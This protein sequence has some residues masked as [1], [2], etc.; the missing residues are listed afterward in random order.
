MSKFSIQNNLYSENILSKNL[1]SNFFRVGNIITSPT[2]T[3][4]SSYTIIP[5]GGITNIILGT[6]DN[7][8]SNISIDLDIDTTNSE[9]GDIINIYFKIS[10]PGSNNVNINLSSSF[11]YTQCGGYQ[12][13]PNFNSFERLALPFIFDGEKFV[14]TYDNC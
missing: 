13:N 7:S 11:Y 5:N 12:A 2:L 8:S 3:N 10:N 6:L 1:N 4:G 14:N 9:I